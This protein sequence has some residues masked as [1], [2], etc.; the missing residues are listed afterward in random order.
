[1][2]QNDAHFSNNLTARQ[3]LALPHV[4][5]AS[6]DTAGATLAHIGRSTL[7]RWMHDDQ[8][9]SELQRM[10]NEAANLAHVELQGLMLKSVLVLAG[11]LDDPD[12]AAR[13]RAARTALHVALR[14]EET[15]A[16]HKRLDV[17]DDALS[18]LKAQL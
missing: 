1:M 5:F 8:F 12:Q 2:D 7:R 13:L 10:R 14:A 3:S 4:A 6:S 9:R 15:R 18:L 17:L 11:A 16:L